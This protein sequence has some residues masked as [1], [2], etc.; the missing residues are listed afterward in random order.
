MKTHNGNRQERASEIGAPPHLQEQSLFIV[1]E[2]LSGRLANL[3]E[4]GLE[5][6]LVD[7][8]I[9]QSTQRLFGFG[10]LALRHQPARALGREKEQ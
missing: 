5:L 8:G 4:F 3:I 2:L 6:E 1:L 7:V 9:A 10:F